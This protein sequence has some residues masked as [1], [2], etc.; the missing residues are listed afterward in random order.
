VNTLVNY[1]NQHRFAKHVHD[2]VEMRSGEESLAPHPTY[3]FVYHRGDEWRPAFH[4]INNERP[5]SKLCGIFHNLGV[6]AEYLRVF[7]RYVEPNAVFHLL[8][9]VT[10]LFVVPDAITIPTD[11]GAVQLEGEI[12]NQT[13]VPYVHVNIPNAPAGLLRNIN[14]IAELQPALKSSGWGRWLASTSAAWA[15]GV[16]SG[17]LATPG[18]IV[19]GV[20]A[21]LT[22]PVIL[23][24]VAVAGII[25]GTGAATGAATATM[26]AMFTGQKVEEAWDRSDKAKKERS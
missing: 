2:L 19:L 3:F 1:E 12:H 7:R 10:E 8:V 21:V 6:M 26:S 5:L 9:P 11:L 22:V 20:A 4:A 15:V 23:P 16:P 24:E 17:I 25:L 13:G 14:N 18:G